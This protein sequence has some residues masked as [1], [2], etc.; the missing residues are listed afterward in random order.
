MKYNNKKDTIK[1]NYYI[2]I[3]KSF[4]SSVQSFFIFLY[5]LDK[6]IYNIYIYIILLNFIGSHTNRGVFEHIYII[7][8]FYCIFFSVIFHIYY[9]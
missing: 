9:F 1:N 2:N 4:S 3:L 8:I 5:G 7:M 6:L